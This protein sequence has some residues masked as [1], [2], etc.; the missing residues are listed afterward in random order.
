VNDGDFSSC[1]Q[2]LAFFGTVTAAVSHELANILLIVDQVGGLLG[3]LAGSVASG[4]NVSS[5][6]LNVLHDRITRQTQRGIE[7][8]KALNRFAHSIDEPDQP[9]GVNSQVETVLILTRRLLAHAQVELS[10][11]WLEEEISLKG[12]PFLVMNIFFITLNEALR[13]AGKGDLIEVELIENHPFVTIV[14]DGPAGTS[15][16]SGEA[17]QDRVHILAEELG[18]GVKIRTEGERRRIHLQFP[19]ETELTTL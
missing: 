17:M 8:I 12:S 14:V 19:R 6:R 9:V 3:D 16:V 13:T 11:R 4:Q 5:E 2:E 18:G 10:V 15:P 1:S 7:Q